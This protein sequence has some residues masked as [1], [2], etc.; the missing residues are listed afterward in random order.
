MTEL[1]E[2]DRQLMSLLQEDGRLSYAE[3]AT[4]AGISASGARL[5]VKRLHEQGILQVVGVSDPLRLG[6]QSMS[7]LGV[8]VTGDAQEVADALGRI[9]EVVYVVLVA[10]SVDLLVEVVA[11][12]NDALFDVING[13][14][15]ALPGVAR[16]E[17]FSY[18]RIHTHRFTW[19]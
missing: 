15:K 16:V 7:M 19:R 13:T 5:R 6:Y 1:D 11:R 17:T 2:T 12:D 10:G 3:L 14:I 18:Y 4:R 8:Q 9:D